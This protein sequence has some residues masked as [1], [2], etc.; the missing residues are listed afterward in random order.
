MAFTPMNEE[1]ITTLLNKTA[2][3]IRVV[4]DII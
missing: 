1:T 2:A 4:F 3:I